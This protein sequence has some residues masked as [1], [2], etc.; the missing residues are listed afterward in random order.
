MKKLVIFT[1]FAALICIGAA[2]ATANNYEEQQ[3]SNEISFTNDDPTPAIT[4]F[5]K[6]YFP[7]ANI[8]IVHPEWDEFDVKLSD[9]TKLEFTR[10]FEWKKIDCEHSTIY[11]NVPAELI[12]E[13]ISNYI[14]TNFAD[15]GIVK[16][17]KKRRGWDVELSSEI[18]IKFNKN[19]VVTK[20]DD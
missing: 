11:P 17:E 9:G 1:A 5:V 4:S 12:P 13:K 2:N 8:L 20:L 19:F 7:K 15:Q 18:E 16:I 6:K 10:G 3:V 14:N